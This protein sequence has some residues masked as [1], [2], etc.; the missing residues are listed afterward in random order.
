MYWMYILYSQ[1]LDKYYIG[2]T[3]DLEDRVDRHNAGRSGYTKPGRP[4]ELAYTEQFKTRSEAVKREMFLK[5]P[6]GWLQLK[7]IKKQIQS[8]RSAAR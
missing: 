6:A 5:S 4:W 7:K 3:D 8:E 1:R 2:Q